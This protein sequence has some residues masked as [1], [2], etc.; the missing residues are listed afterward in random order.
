VTTESLDGPVL[1]HGVRRGGQRQHQLPRRIHHAS[2]TL[3]T[4]CRRSRGLAARALQRVGP[5]GGLNAHPAPRGGRS[6]ASLQAA[7]SKRRD[8]LGSVPQHPR[9]HPDLPT[10]SATNT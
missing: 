7:A 6:T 1:E 8:P 4:T 10:P 9:R 5:G 2:A 3:S